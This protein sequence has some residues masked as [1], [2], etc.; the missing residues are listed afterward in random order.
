MQPVNGFSI[1]GTEHLGCSLSL[2]SRGLVLR[3]RAPFLFEVPTEKIGLARDFLGCFIGF[4]NPLP[5]SNGSGKARSRE[6]RRGCKQQQRT[7][8]VGI[9]KNQTFFPLHRRSKGS[10]FFVGFLPELA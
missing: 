3:H 10:R 9:P 6:N 5:P 1:H 8:G 7:R 2:L 4:L